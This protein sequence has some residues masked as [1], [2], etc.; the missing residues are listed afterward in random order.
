MLVRALRAAGAGPFLGVVVG[1]R[2]NC[3]RA[4]RGRR[5]VTCATTALLAA[6]HACAV[7]CA[8]SALARLLAVRPVGVLLAFLRRASYLSEVM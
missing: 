7:P 1:R 8:A 6:L 2:E 4:K 5:G 3:W